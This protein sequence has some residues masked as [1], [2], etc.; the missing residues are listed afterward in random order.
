MLL[1]GHAY[2]ARPQGSTPSKQQQQGLKGKPAQGTPAPA[3][4]KPGN[5]PGN[6]EASRWRGSG[7]DTI[8]PKQQPGQ[9]RGQSGGTGQGRATGAAGGPGAYADRPPRPGQQGGALPAGAGTL[10]SS[11]SGDGKGSG[12]GGDK[13]GSASGGVGQGSG[14]GG[15]TSSG[16]LGKGGTAQRLPPAA[17]QPG[18]SA[19]AG[20]SPSPQQTKGDRA[21]VGAGG[22]SAASSITG[23]GTGPATMRP[24]GG[25]VAG[26]TPK[27]A[28]GFASKPATRPATGRAP[29]SGQASGFSSGVGINAT[30]LAGA[31][32]SSGGF[33]DKRDHTRNAPAGVKSSPTAS[34]APTATAAT[35]SA[36]A[37]Y[38]SRNSGAAANPS[39]NS[40]GSTTGRSSPTPTPRLIG[41]PAIG[42]A[43]AQAGG[44]P[45]A[46]AGA[47]FGA[48]A[49]AAAAQQPGGRAGAA[50]GGA[51]QVQGVDRSRSGVDSSGGG[52]QDSTIGDVKVVGMGAPPLGLVQQQQ[53]RQAEGQPQGQG[54]ATEGSDQ[55][56]LAEEGLGLHTNDGVALHDGLA[57]QDGRQQ[58]EAQPQQAVVQDAAEQQGQQGEASAAWEDAEQQLQQQ[59]E[60]QQQQREDID[61]GTLLQQR[62]G[63]S[64]TQAGTL[65]TQQ[66]GLEADE[67]SS[68][69]QQEEEVGQLIAE[70]GASAAVQEEG[71][72]PTAEEGTFAAV[73]EK[74]GQPTAEGPFAL[75][76]DAGEGQ[77]AAE[78]D[79][80]AAQ[81]EDGGQTTAQEGSFVAL[82]DNGGQP[83][84]QE[85]PFAAQ[86]LDVQEPAAGTA[87]SVPS[88]ALQEGKGQEHGQYAVWEGEDQQQ[89][90][91]GHEYGQTAAQEDEG[92]QSAG[93]EGAHHAYGQEGPLEAFPGVPEHLAVDGTLSAGQ[94]RGSQPDAAAAQPEG[95]AGENWVEEGR[96]EMELDAEAGEAEAEMVEEEAGFQAEDGE[97]QDEAEE[98]RELQEAQTHGQ[99]QG[100]QEVHAAAAADA[101]QYNAV[102]GN[103]EQRYDGGAEPFAEESENGHAAVAQP[104]A[105]TQPLASS[106]AQPAV[107]PSYDASQQAAPRQPRSIPSAS[108]APPAS[109]APPPPPRA[110]VSGGG[111]GEFA[112][113]SGPPPAPPKGYAARSAFTDAAAPAA[114][115]PKGKLAPKLPSIKPA[116]N[117]KQQRQS[118]KEEEAKAK[119]VNER[120][121]KWEMGIPD[122]PAYTRPQLQTDWKLSQEHLEWFASRGIGEETL[123]INGVVT[124]DKWNPATGKVEPAVAFCYYKRGQLVNVKFRHLPKVFH[125][126]SAGHE[127][128]GAGSVHRQRV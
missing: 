57:A 55:G 67:A 45:A 25:Y 92:P 58:G 5:Q 49:A 108:P 124:A 24:A 47:V 126:V 73:Q 93:Q 56:G 119:L 3:P 9:Q 20:S 30:G 43:A 74:G 64:A 10:R 78:G 68:A 127:G 101:Q 105:S 13:A 14:S 21:P 32:A 59:R 17:S 80:L 66:P 4:S 46:A 53:A 116:I 27:P 98:G 22:S 84:A 90:G 88:M 125:Q 40:G 106:A 39:L 51:T 54:E 85:S 128:G 111:G 89:G 37:A 109:S 72:Q 81:E 113:A 95:G 91:A 79:T 82:Q 50:A 94:Q 104:F 18:G 65:D 48:G 107:S 63:R 110:P 15:V 120:Y 103:M 83:A 62:D 11:S 6:G 52:V 99:G 76:H 123:R 7:T 114:A 33:N 112:Y 38:A 12:S 31:P 28:T 44:P 97:G 23:Q 115:A 36:G 96:G 26:P 71:G 87:S 35:A 86:Q 60:Q 77:L 75:Q 19:W 42:K 70:E 2:Q 16:G 102:P 122:R 118:V 117:K 121:E 100:W 8:T 1:Q 41:I 29:F 34:R 61:A 69:L